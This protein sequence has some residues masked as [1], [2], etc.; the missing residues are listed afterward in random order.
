[1]HLGKACIHLF[2]IPSSCELNCCVDWTLSQLV[3]VSFRR[4]QGISISISIIKAT[5]IRHPQLVYAL[6]SAIA[7]CSF[8]FNKL[9]WYLHSF[10]EL[11]YAYFPLC[12]FPEEDIVNDSFL[13]LQQCQLNLY[14]PLRNH[15]DQHRQLA[16]KHLVNHRLLTADIFTPSSILL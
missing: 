8:S 3:V 13:L 6:R 12:K 11:R 9:N 7:V 5:A 16:I 1:M 14:F 10:G 4:Q 2:P 15:I